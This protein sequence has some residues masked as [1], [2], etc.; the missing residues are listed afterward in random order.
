MCIRKAS[1][2]CS[3]G[4]LIEDIHFHSGAHVILT[5]DVPNG[6]SCRGSCLAVR[7]PSFGCTV[8]SGKLFGKV[9]C[10]KDCSSLGTGGGEIGSTAGTG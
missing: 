10:C 9:A 4:A 7:R 1:F 6:I 2:F 3:R 8:T 5:K